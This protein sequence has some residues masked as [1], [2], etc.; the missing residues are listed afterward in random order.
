MCCH[1]G[2]VQMAIVH[3]VS[4]QMF[5]WLEWQFFE[6]LGGITVVHARAST[7]HQAGEEANEAGEAREQKDEQAAEDESKDSDEE[8]V[9]L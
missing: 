1:V 2:I 7:A 3:T 5:E 9:Q 8:L 4:A 6:T